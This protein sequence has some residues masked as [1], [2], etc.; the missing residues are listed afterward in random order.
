M[1]FG[2][3][4]NPLYIEKRNMKEKIFIDSDIILDVLLER[5][6]FYDSSA[7][8]FDLGVSKET[9]LFTTAL[10]LANVFYFIRKK[11]GIEKSKALLRQLRLFINILPIKETIVDMAL[12]S[13]FS[14]F[15]DGLQYFTSKEHSIKALIT[16]NGKDYKEK[17]VI[18]QTPDEYLKYKVKELQNRKNGPR[19]R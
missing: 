3:S 8:I 7:E 19:N 12:N 15:E 6:P 14:D 10:I 2:G 13:K 4:K 18:I 9:G 16:R 11:F 5:V 17:G 1:G